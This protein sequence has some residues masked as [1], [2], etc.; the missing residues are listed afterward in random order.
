MRA[1]LAS[2]T[3]IG[4]ALVAAGCGGHTA[5]REFGALPSSQGQVQ[6]AAP[7][8][9]VAEPAPATATPA[10][11]AVAAATPDTAAL[12]KSKK[13]E[14]RL[15][16][17][18]L[19]AARRLRATRAAA[20]KARK[21]AAAREKRLKD[22]LAAA[23]VVMP[24]VR[25]KHAPHRAS[26]APLTASDVNTDE[27][28]RAARVAV[29]RFHQ[30]LDQH[31]GAACSLLSTRFLNDHF[32]GAD[33]DAQRSSCRT[34]VAGLDRS[35]SVLVESSGS[36]PGGAWVKVIA[37]YGDQQRPEIIHLVPFIEAWLIDSVAPVAQ[38]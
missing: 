26:S 4:V 33:T 31:D 6:A 3:L 16:H 24:A 9:V 22:E 28:A 32:P 19:V 38:R 15:R 1:H 11:P 20:A 17:D 2:T 10:A 35:V 21:H 29:V 37:T 30:L 25:A 18:R 8:V 34:G 13:A 14:K 12:A 7:P 23:K 36:E 27:N 5:S